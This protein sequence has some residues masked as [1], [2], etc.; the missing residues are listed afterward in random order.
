M[1]FKTTLQKEPKHTELVS[2]VGW[3]TPEEVFSASDDHQILKWN[4]SGES[5]S[6]AKLPEDVFPTDLHWFPKSVTGGGKKQGGS[7][8]FVLGSCDGK[9]LLVTKSGRIEK[10][11][12]AHRGAVLSTRW[13]YDGT[14]L[15]SSKT[16]NVFKKLAV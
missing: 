1:R 9:I 15:V 14:A 3:T 2:C 13:S 6:L 8:L 16:K 7:D 4:V 12:D 11:V 5:S 10:T